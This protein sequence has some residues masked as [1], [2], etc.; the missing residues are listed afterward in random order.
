[1]T[2]QFWEGQLLFSNSA[3]AMDPACCC[4]G[5]DPG[6]TPTCTDLFDNLLEETVFT[7]PMQG[8]RDNINCDACRS[9]NTTFA[10]TRWTSADSLGA[11]YWR[12]SAVHCQEGDGGVVVSTLSITQN[13]FTG[14]FTVELSFRINRIDSDGDGV[15]WNQGGISATYRTE[16]PSGTTSF[17]SQ[18]TLPR[19][20]IDNVPS[21]GQCVWLTPPPD[22]IVITKQ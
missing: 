11:C 2:L 22:P 18:L 14:V 1:M 10:L 7:H 21:N 8:L 19:V 4:D 16:L 15:P 6:G 20:G 9:L 13:I 5:G 12:Y 17:P 3:L